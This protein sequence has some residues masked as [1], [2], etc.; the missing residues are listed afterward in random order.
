MKDFIRA[1]TLICSLSIGTHALAADEAYLDMFWQDLVPEGAT[2]PKE[3]TLDELHDLS[4]ILEEQNDPNIG[5]E[6]VPELAGQKVKLP[7]YIIPLDTDA[8]KT[9]EFLLVPFFGACI[10]VPPPPPN[11]I[12]YGTSKEGLSNQL[13]DALWVYGTM[14]IET[15]SSELAEA[16]YSMR[17]D[18]V[19]AMELD[20]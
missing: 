16:G 11:Q 4:A 10:H 6:V 2:Q 18:Y 17:V 8:K 12:V 20:E 5:R 13:F 1:C 3:Y 19:E 14:G 7:A 9:H 15:V